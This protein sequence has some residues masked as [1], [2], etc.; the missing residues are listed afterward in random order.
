M[1][2]RIDVVAANSKNKIDF[3]QEKLKHIH[4]LNLQNHKDK[5][6]TIKVRQREE[7]QFF[8]EGS[9]MSP[10]AYNLQ[11]LFKTK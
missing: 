7:T 11:M 1:S 9:G 8:K 5:G 10:V 3:K 2:S 4:T 6:K